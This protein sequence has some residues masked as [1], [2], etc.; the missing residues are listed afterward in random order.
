M[1]TAVLIAAWAVFVVALYWMHS[2]FEKRR[3]LMDKAG[4]RRYK[5]MQLI[6][7]QENWRALSEDF[8]EVSFEE[9]WEATLSGKDPLS[10]YPPRIQMMMDRHYKDRQIS[11]SD[12]V[13]KLN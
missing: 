7:K 1:E 5:M 12:N 11:K 3:K 8:D 9:F 13:V 10:L 2:H 6:Y 4:E